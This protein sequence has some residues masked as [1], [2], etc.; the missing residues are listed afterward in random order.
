LPV[1]DSIQHTADL[2]EVTSQTWAYSF[3]TQAFDTTTDGSSPNGVHYFN[4]VV[5]YDVSSA[6][7]GFWTATV[8]GTWL[9]NVFHVAPPP[10]RV[11]QTS[12]HW[13]QSA[14]LNLTTTFILGG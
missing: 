12:I 8:G 1:P 10:T 13:N 14:W 9:G 6:P 11:Y 4:Q 5:T 2:G 3:S 7:G